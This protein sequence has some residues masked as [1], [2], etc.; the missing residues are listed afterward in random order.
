[1]HFFFGLPLIPSSSSHKTNLQGTGGKT[2]LQVLKR[3]HSSLKLSGHCTER[4][5]CGQRSTKAEQPSASWLWQFFRV[6][7]MPLQFGCL[8]STLHCGTT[9][10]GKILCGCGLPIIFPLP[11]LSA[12]ILKTCL[13]V[14]SS[15][16]LFY[17][18][19]SFSS[20]L[21]SLLWRS[22]H[23][24]H[25]PHR[26]MSSVKSS[27]HGGRPGLEHTWWLRGSCSVH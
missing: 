24:T 11:I 2:W 9:T 3:K 18:S 13:A 16:F 25:P 23:S 20:L 15:Y 27:R 21:Q 7:R 8:S 12:N 26:R 17:F 1:M 10:L 22:Q 14:Y 19:L 5:L 4:C 6:E